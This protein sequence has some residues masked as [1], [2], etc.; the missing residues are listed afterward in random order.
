VVLIDKKAF[1][2]KLPLGS[3]APAFTLPCTDGDS[4]SLA[5]ISTPLVVVVFWCNHCPYVKAALDALIDITRTHKGY[6]TVI[7]I[8]SNDAAQYPED[9]F[10]HMQHEAR[11]H[12]V[13]FRYLYDETQEVAK[14]YGAECTPHVFVFDQQRRLRYQGR[15]NDA[16]QRAGSARTT[17]LHDALVAIEAGNEPPHPLTAALG[18]S[19]KWTQ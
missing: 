8:N 7:A 3:M 11:L 10:E 2:Y 6:A 1:D 18:C 4:V 19:I 16:G 14:A 5:D 13:P 15:I 12:A 17:E 9:G